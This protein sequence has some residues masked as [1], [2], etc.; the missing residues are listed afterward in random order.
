MQATRKER[1]HSAPGRIASQ[2]GLGLQLGVRAFTSMSY[3]LSS[4]LLMAA[5][6]QPGPQQ[7]RVPSYTATQSL[8]ETQATA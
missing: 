3:L 8:S 1:S 7:P 2:G 5:F 4:V 6:A